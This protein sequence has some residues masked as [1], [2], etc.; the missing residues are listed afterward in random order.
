[1][2]GGLDSYGRAVRELASL[3]PGRSAVSVEWETSDPAAP[4]SL[5]ARGDEPMLLALGEAQFD[6]PESFPAPGRDEPP[7][8]AA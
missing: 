6:L 4:L 2:L 8:S 7:L 3:F 5:A 1:M